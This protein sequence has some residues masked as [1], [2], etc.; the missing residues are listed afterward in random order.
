MP[1]VAL[2]VLTLTLAACKGPAALDAGTPVER[3][4]DLRSAVTTVFPEYRGTA[5]LVA[6]AQVTRTV[7]PVSQPQLEQVRATATQ[8]G[9]SGEPPTR[10]PFVLEQYLDG[11]VLTQE[12]RMAVS[13][14]ELGRILSAPSAMTS[15]A[16]AH[17]I[18]KLSGG[19]RREEF[20]VEL[21]W[22]A[23][24]EARADFLV[25]QLTDGA[26]SAGWQTE[27]PKG[28]ER[29]RDGGPPQVPRELFL[30]VKNDALGARFEIERK[31][32]RARLRYVLTT[33]E[34]R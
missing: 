21:V 5:V 32:E 14:D 6:R 11:G 20:E 23:K 30:T 27:L 25:W 29:Y 13:S 33:F 4:T 16:M 26:L 24:D 22:I 8:N 17:W 15:E 31:A 34:R 3:G 28:F 19:E 18:P 1:K 2:A 10:K 9:F 7:A 12:L